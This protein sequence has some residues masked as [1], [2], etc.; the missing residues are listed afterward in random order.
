MIHVHS[1]VSTSPAVTVCNEEWG[2]RDWKEGVR[3]YKDYLVGIEMGIKRG[4]SA[5]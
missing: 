2:S 5:T 1:E 3:D 4:C